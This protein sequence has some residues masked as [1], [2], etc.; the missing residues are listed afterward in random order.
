[1]D[2]LNT[3]KTEHIEQRWNPA[4]SAIWGRKPLPWVEKNYRIT[5]HELKK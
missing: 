1:M 4:T 5:E 2:G 3:A